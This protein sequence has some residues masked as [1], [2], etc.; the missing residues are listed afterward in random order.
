M[1]VSDEGWSPSARQVERESP[2]AP[3][4]AALGDRG[5]R[6]HGRRARP[7]G[8]GGHHVAGLA[9]RQGV[10][11][12]LGGRQG[13]VPRCAQG[14]R[15]ERPAVHD[16]RA[17]DPGARRARG[18]GEVDHVGGAVPAA[19]AGGL[20]HRP[21][22]GRAD[23]A[24]GG[25]GGHRHSRP[26]PPGRHHRP[27]LARAAGARAVVRRLRRGGLPRRHR[28]D[29]PLAGGECR[30]ARPLARTGDA[31]RR[32][33][34]GDPARGAPTAQRLHLAAEGHRPAVGDLRLRGV[35]HGAPTTRRT[36]STTRRSSSS[37]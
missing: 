12:L 29:P 28:L 9:A 11:L 17:P 19:A 27:V 16:R 5:H 21:V 18:G 8:P 31:L 24:R 37:R 33:A 2:A 32:A 13:R 7:A 26:E 14:L 23:A 35:V 4:A 30:R 20:L 25:A 1:T 3:H 10:L 34:A 36:T 22:P 15:Q 6:R